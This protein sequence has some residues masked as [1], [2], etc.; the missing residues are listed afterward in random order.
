MKTIAVLTDLSK[1]S[2]H[3]TQFALHIARKMKARVLLF[4]VN[5]V[6]AAR[7]QLVLTG[8]PELFTE[9]M[10]ALAEFAQ[11]ME[12]ELAARSFPGSLLPE[13]QA[14]CNSCGIVDA[15]TAIMG[16]E[17]VVLLVTAP[18]PGNDTADYILGDA[19]NRII[20][21]ARVPV[22]VVPET[23]PLR[24]FEKIAFASQ[25]HEEDI[26]SI[27]ELDSLMADFSAELMVAHLNNDPSDTRIRLAGEKLNRDLYRKLNCGGVYFRSIPDTDRQRNWDWLKANKRTDLLAVV[28]QPRAQLAQFFNRGENE[29]TTYHLTIPV[30][31]LPKRP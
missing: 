24:N 12:Q 11:E 17:D 20:D 18:T 26:Y 14:D 31:V 9:V 2:G 5:P 23:A 27:G 6:P 30:M 29:E 4:Q 22:L 3:A 25:L 7:K 21:W 15:M 8:E 10:P 16:N 28:H 13:V 1:S 19:C